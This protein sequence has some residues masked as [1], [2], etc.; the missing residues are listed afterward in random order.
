MVHSKQMLTGSSYSCAWALRITLRILTLDQESRPN[1]RE[2]WPC[3]FMDAVADFVGCDLFS[4]DHVPLVARFV[5]LFKVAF[6]TDSSSIDKVK[7]VYCGLLVTKLR[8]QGVEVAT[9]KKTTW[10]ALALHVE[11]MIRSTTK[12]F[13]HKFVLPMA[14][15]NSS[16]LASPRPTARR[17]TCLMPTSPRDPTDTSARRLRG[18]GTLS[19]TASIGEVC[20]GDLVELHGRVT[21]PSFSGDTKTGIATGMDIRAPDIIRLMKNET[22]KLKRTRSS[23]GGLT[24]RDIMALGR[25]RDDAVVLRDTM[26][27]KAD[28]AVFVA[29]GLPD[30]IHFRWVYKQPQVM[31]GVYE[32]MAK[33]RDEYARRQVALQV[34]NSHDLGSLAIDFQHARQ[35]LSRWIDQDPS[36]PDDFMAGLQVVAAIVNRGLSFLQ[37]VLSVVSDAERTRHPWLLGRGFVRLGQVRPLNHL[38]PPQ[39]YPSCVRAAS[40]VHR[41]VLVVDLHC[42]PPHLGLVLLANGP[43]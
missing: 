40:A 12:P 25:W 9:I 43:R 4:Y 35:C 39:K 8:A 18:V 10:V 5:A 29:A 13:V 15:P 21:A 41:A 24:D 19:W 27:A 42:G 38:Q 7:S 36:P 2:R 34:I 16:R 1:W 33:Y 28:Q 32:V 37:P 26:R 3:S 30:P 14:R 22:M 6:P 11:N 31:F 23:R 17:R 20:K